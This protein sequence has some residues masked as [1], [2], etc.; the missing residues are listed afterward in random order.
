ME[1]VCFS[2]SSIWSLVPNKRYEVLNENVV[3]CLPSFALLL[4]SR[5]VHPH[6]LIAPM[7]S[8]WSGSREGKIDWTEVTRTIHKTPI[9]I[10]HRN[11]IKVITDRWGYH[12]NECHENRTTNNWPELK[13]WHKLQLFCRC[14]LTGNKWYHTLN[15]WF[16]AFKIKNLH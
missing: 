9:L 14:I 15:Y 13:I 16:N 12:R 7:T 5:F 3:S 8:T 10:I 11:T 1:N 2:N 4:G 6:I